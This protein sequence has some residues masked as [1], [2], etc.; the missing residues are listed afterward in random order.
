MICVIDYGAG[1]LKSVSNALNYIG[2]ENKVS[3]DRDEILAADKILLPGVG[4]FGD[5]MA[6]LKKY[7]LV[8]TVY[9]AVESGKPFMGICLGMQLLFEDSQESPGV[10]GLGIFKGHILKFPGDMGLKV[11]QI[12]WNNLNVKNPSSVYASAH[13]KYVYFVHSYYLEAKDPSIVAAECE[14][15]KIFHA[16]VEKGNVSASQFHP[17]KSGETG[18]QILKNWAER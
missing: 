16:A 2:A 15:G 14:Y 17:E 3:A 10:A 13:D 6:S 9:D 1:N 4:A 12:G 5:A 7:G 11:P 8:N 18:L